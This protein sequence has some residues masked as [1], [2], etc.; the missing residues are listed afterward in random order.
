MSKPKTPTTHDLV[1][2]INAVREPDGE[3]ESE[4]V[5]SLFTEDLIYIEWLCRL[6]SP[7]QL[8]RLLEREAQPLW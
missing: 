8:D 5:L 3:M 1:N 4:E 7:E 2:M 6:I